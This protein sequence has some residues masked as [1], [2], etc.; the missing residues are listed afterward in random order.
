MYRL[1]IAIDLPTEI[2]SALNSLM[3]GLTCGKAVPEGQLHLTLRFIGNA[4]QDQLQQI[5]TALGQVRCA[6]FNLILG[7]IGHFPAGKYPK[8]LWT[9]IK[10]HH[11]LHELKEKIDAA[12]LSAGMEPDGRSFAP[13]VTIARFKTAS[14][15]MI[16]PF[17]QQHL[18]FQT[19][20]FRVTEFFLYD[21]T[22]T[23]A[24]AMH[25]KIAAFTLAATGQP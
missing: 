16:A 2:R 12:L 9:G 3:T 14:T 19:K 5:T 11:I 23:A 13:H 25:K 20:P 18:A 24:G 10:T 1:F 8:V 7:G 21:S 4:D 17:E 6:T 22:L 15:A